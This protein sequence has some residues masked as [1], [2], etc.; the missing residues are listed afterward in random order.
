MMLR[1]F[2]FFACLLPAL[3]DAHIRL[4]Q[5]LPV[6]LDG[7]AVRLKLRSYQPEGP[8]PFP[9]LIFHHG[10]TGRGNDPS[11]FG[12]FFDPKPLVDW[13][14]QRRWAVMLPARRGRGGSEGLYDEGFAARRESGYT[15]TPELS[16]PGAERAMRDIE[17]ITQAIIAKP[18]V[19]RQR[20]LIGGQSRGGI[21]SVAYAGRQPDLFK[22]V[23]N[24]V[25]GWMSTGCNTASHINLT[26][27]RSGARY[28][29]DMLWLY[30]D[31]D[32][33]YE[34]SHSRDNH[35]QFLKAG[36]RG[37][38]LAYA[39]PERGDGHG[40]LY[41]PALWSEALDAYLS[42]RLGAASSGAGSSR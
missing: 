40:I 12:S 2:V 10:S 30:G 26:L 11:R 38:F 34:L 13:F 27:F 36:G 22:G 9:T 42:Q 35:S 6:T 16:L 17:A 32:P 23:I 19:D 29:A 3:A 37:Q 33:Y 28:P 39:K 25:G 4:D 18:V 14:V 7:E 20:L 41:N 8:G 21:L 31:G 5:D 15:C 24:F 1:L